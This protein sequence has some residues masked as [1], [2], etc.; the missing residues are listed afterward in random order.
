MVD[1]LPI[2]PHLLYEACKIMSIA[3]SDFINIT[4]PHTLP[5]VCGNCD[6][7]VLDLIAKEVPQFSKVLVNHLPAILAHI[8]LLPSQPATTKALTFLVQVIGDDMTE[9]LIRSIVRV[10]VYALLAALVVK[11]GDDDPRMAERVNSTSRNF[12]SCITNQPLQGP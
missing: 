5:A 2:Q 3:P 7:T 6:R 8:F 12:L 11:M 10:N 1:R 9:S 4:L